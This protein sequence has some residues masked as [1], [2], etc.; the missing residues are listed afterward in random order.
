MEETVML[1]V[2]TGKVKFFR[3]GQG[4]GFIT[5]DQGGESVFFHVRYFSG[6]SEVFAGELELVFKND[7][8]LSEPLPTLTAGDPIAYCD[9]RGDRGLMAVHWLSLETWGKAQRTMAGRPGSSMNFSA[10]V[11]RR[12]SGLEPIIIWQGFYDDLCNKLNEGFPEISSGEGIVEKLEIDGQWRRMW[13]PT[14]W[15]P[16]YKRV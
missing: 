11:V 15:H 1:E 4:W 10:R 9:F 13:Q 16:K 12:D 14:E 2:K 8:T 6:V 7:A 5:P 3:L